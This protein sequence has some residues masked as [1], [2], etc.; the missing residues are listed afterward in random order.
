VYYVTSDPGSTY[1]W[2]ILSGDAE[3]SKKNGHTIE[4]NVGD[5]G[6]VIVKVIQTTSD[7]CK[8]ET[9]QEIV[10]KSITGVKEEMGKSFSVY[11]NPNNGQEELIIELPSTSLHKMRVELI[12]LLGITRYEGMIPSQ[13]SRHVIQRSDMPKGMYTIRLIMRDGVL[14]EKVIVE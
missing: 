4:L 7:G 10:V 14:S 9:Q 8:N 12:D 2:I 3:I 1:E 11:P 13:T 5:P 6:T